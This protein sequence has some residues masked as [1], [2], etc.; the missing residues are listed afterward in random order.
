[1][2]IKSTGSR[3]KTEHHGPVNS[4]DATRFFYELRMLSLALL[5][6]LSCKKGKEVR[7]GEDLEGLDSLL[8]NGGV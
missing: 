3:G 4:N 5:G 7:K 2:L 6:F 1:M 8:I